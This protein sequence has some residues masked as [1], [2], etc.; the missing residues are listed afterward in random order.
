MNKIILR[1]SLA[2]TFV[3]LTFFLAALQ[4]PHIGEG[5][6]DWHT[7]KRPAI[8]AS[9]TSGS[10]LDELH[11]DIEL[12]LYKTVYLKGSTP[13]RK[14][15]VVKAFWIETLNC[16]CYFDDYGRLCAVPEHR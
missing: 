1:V 2:L 6:E 11:P 10:S 13:K 8:P 4:I 16:Y 12:E 5:A 9:K 3:S 15:I 7:V 14:R